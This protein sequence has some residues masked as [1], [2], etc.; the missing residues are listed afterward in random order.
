MFEI[1]SVF[2]LYL[3]HESQDCHVKKLEQNHFFQ[4]LLTGFDI[5]K[6]YY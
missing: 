1:F 3:V 5:S 6:I 4:C 2:Q